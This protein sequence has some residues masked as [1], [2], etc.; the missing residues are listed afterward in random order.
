MKREWGQRPR[1]RT[2]EISLKER[3][4]RERV[5]G[6]RKAL[7]GRVWVGPCFWV[8]SGLARGSARVCRVCAGGELLVGWLRAR[9]R[10]K[11]YIYS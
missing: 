2:R 4:R 1:R 7:G 9:I 5:L 11:K 10:P 6:R 3:E 8:G